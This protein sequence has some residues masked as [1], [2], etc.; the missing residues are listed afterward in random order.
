MIE[1]VSRQWSPRWDGQAPFVETWCATLNHVN[2]GAGFWIRYAIVV[3]KGGPA[4]GEVWFAS[5]TPGRESA[6]AAVGCRF[7]EDD[8]EAD[9]D[10]GFC[11][12]RTV[13]DRAGRDDRHARDRRDAR[14][15][16]TRVQTG[17]RSPA[18]HA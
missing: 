9:R 6:S 8:V 2:S 13:P 18:L 7:A 15:M 17:N 4:R 3:P 10:L 14:D 1:G 11:A 16:G 12:D 5:F